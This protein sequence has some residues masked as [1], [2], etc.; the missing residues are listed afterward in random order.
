MM[1]VKRFFIICTLVIFLL[2]AAGCASSRDHTA[3]YRSPTDIADP[4]EPLNRMVFGFNTVVDAVIVEPVARAYRFILP[5]PVRD[6]V[7]N[8]M[9]NLRTPL[10]FA[11]NVLQGDIGDAGVSVARFVI[12]TTVGIGGLFDVAATQGLE[13]RR[14]DLGQTFGRWGIGHGFYVVLPVLGPSS[15]RDG[16]GMAGDIWADPV[17]IYAFNQDKKWIYY[18]RGGVEAVDQ[19]SRIIEAV[20]DLRRNSHDYYAV[21]RSIYGQQRYSAVHNDPYAHLGV[22]DLDDDL[23]DD[24]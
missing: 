5:S 11:H 13:Y 17:R 24:Y 1:C 22:M 19:R 7:Q 9:R 8:F 12:N 20:S 18:T 2:P 15:L 23:Y 4:F 10:N 21:V 3:G 16:V 14:E 6:S